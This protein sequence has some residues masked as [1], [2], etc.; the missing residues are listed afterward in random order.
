MCPIC[1]NRKRGDNLRGN[2]ND[3]LS[4]SKK[5]HG[6]KYDYSKVEYINN[7]T[8]VCIICPE[9]GEFWQTPY[10]HM[11]GFGCK[12]CS[13]I[14][15]TDSF[16]KKAKEIYHNKYDYSKVKYIHSKEKVCIICPEH[17]EFY[18]T[19]NNFLKGHSCPICKQS[20]LENEVRVFL[21]KNNIKF[22]LQKRFIWLGML[23]YDFYLPDYN[24]AIECQGEQHFKVV[25]WFG[26]EEGFL[27]QKKFDENKKKLSYDNNIKI[28]YYTHLKYKTFLGQ[29][30]IYT[31]DELLNKIYENNEEKGE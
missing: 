4:R 28:L 18:V 16:I 1:A 25:K 19:P 26:G 15:D 31:L 17:G 29:K 7:K 23:R 3:F 10:S 11:V 6:N 9:H 21:I 8:K 5:I 13:K 12:K 27:M 22:E 14:Y 24:I 30:L 20:H 2:I